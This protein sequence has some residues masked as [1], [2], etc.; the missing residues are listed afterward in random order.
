MRVRSIYLRQSRKARML[1]GFLLLLL[2]VF[3]EIWCDEN[4]SFAAGQGTFNKSTSWRNSGSDCYS[5]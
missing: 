4:N 3:V 2:F 1:R 5:H